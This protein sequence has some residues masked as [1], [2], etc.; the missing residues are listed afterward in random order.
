[1][2][3]SEYLLIP[4][5][6]SSSQ[7]AIWNTWWHDVIPKFH[8]D[9]AI[10]AN[11]I[12]TLAPKHGRI[13]EAGCGQGSWVELLRHYGYDCL[14]IENNPAA[15]SAA[16]KFFPKANIVDGDITKTNLEP[17]SVDMYLSWGVFEHFRDGCQAPLAEALRVL[18]P[19]GFML[20]TI[21]NNNAWRRLVWPLTSI[22]NCLKAKRSVQ[23]LFGKPPSDS[24]W[25]EYLFTE[26]EFARILESAGFT[27]LYS[28]PLFVEHGMTGACPFLAS[29]KN[30][31]LNRIGKLIRS[32]LGKQAYPMFAH[33]NFF[34]AVKPFSDKKISGAAE[35]DAAVKN[36]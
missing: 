22:R 32:I 21:P 8:T 9:S 27:L 16:K 13:L 35:L 18:R 33:M 15:L 17:N 3:V 25:Y 10:L 11:T 23:K 28:K 1:M 26:T 34:V 6:K 29:G 5:D 4:V 14:G 31:E 36:A 7:H 24:V 2:P 20:A 12:L 30:V 19:G